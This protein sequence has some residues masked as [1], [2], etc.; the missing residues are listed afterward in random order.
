MQPSTLKMGLFFL[1]VS[2][3]ESATAITRRS[4]SLTLVF[5]Q[6]DRTHPLALACAP[7][8]G[9]LTKSRHDCLLRILPYAPLNTAI[10]AFCTFSPF[11]SGV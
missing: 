6:K 7:N 2:W 10:P 3:R 5:V 8:N 11:R 4:R 9:L 1:W